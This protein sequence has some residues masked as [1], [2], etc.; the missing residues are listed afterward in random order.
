MRKTGQWFKPASQ[1]RRWR[2]GGQSGSG[3]SSAAWNGRLLV[4]EGLLCVRSALHTWWASANPH[5]SSAWGRRIF[6][7]SC[8]KVS[9]AKSREEPRFKARLR[10]CW[11]PTPAW[12]S[13]RPGSPPVLREPIRPQLPHQVPGA[14]RGTRGLSA[15]TLSS[16]ALPIHFWAGDRSP[17]LV[18]GS[19]PS[20]LFSRTGDQSP[21]GPNRAPPPVKLRNRTWT[22]RGKGGGARRPRLP[23]PAG[24][25]GRRWAGLGPSEGARTAPLG[26]D[27]CRYLA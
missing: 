20:P 26:N 4:L 22:G 19:L 6:P 14:G 8:E 18:L 15:P 10:E 9:C 27:A 24:P 7:I 23:A 13:H 11:G 17:K 25:G 12:A 3:G 1:H 2:P 5:H 16:E 21:G